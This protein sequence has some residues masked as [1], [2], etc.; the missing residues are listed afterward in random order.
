MTTHTE[1]Q[2]TMYVNQRQCTRIKPHQHH[3]YW[4]VSWL[5]CSSSHTEK[6]IPKFW[7][8]QNF[9][10]D[11]DDDYLWTGVMWESQHQ[12]YY[13]I[14]LTVVMSCLR[15]PKITQFVQALN[16]QSTDLKHKQSIKC[17]SLP[18]E[19][20]KSKN[21]GGS[22]LYSPTAQVWIMRQVWF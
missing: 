18:E 14:S 3:F 5:S 15:Q 7:Y 19:S 17:C 11:R 4:W 6:F 10:A 12:R 13:H 16:N 22:I 9:I 20:G 2:P 1:S 21:T 8:C